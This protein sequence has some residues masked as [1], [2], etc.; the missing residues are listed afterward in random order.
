MNQ[1]TIPLSDIESVV[2]SSLLA[3]P[4]FK[5]EHQNEH[6]FRRSRRNLFIQLRIKLM[7]NE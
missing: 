1:E 6:I 3:L 7:S 4:G 5:S 2:V